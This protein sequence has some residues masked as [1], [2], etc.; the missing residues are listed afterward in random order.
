[1]DKVRRMMATYHARLFIDDKAQ[2]DM[3]KLLPAF[4]D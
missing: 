1:M 3:L 4:Y 2:A